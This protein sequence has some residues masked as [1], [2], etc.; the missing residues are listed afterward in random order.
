MISLAPLTSPFTP[1]AAQAYIQDIRNCSTKE[2]ERER[3]DKELGK[4]RKKY[5]SDKAMTGAGRKDLAFDALFGCSMLRG[6][7]DSCSAKVLLL[8]C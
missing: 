8:C 7:L 4:I 3:V 2:A 1:L 5:T 6:G